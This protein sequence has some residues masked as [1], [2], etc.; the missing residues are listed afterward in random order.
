MPP[1]AEICLGALARANL[2]L[3]LSIGGAF[4]L[5]HYLPYRPT[6]DVDAW[7]NEEAGAAGRHDVV[8]CLQKALAPCGEVRVRC[9]GDVSSVE[10]SQ[11]ARTVFSFQIAQRTARLLP[12]HPSPFAGLQVDSLD[13]LVA[14]KMVALVERGAPRDF[15][16]IHAVCTHG[17][18][19]AEQCW[20][21]WHQRQ[22]LADANADRGRATLA[23]RSHLE[24]IV[25]ARP[26][27][28]IADAQARTRAQEVRTWIVGVLLDAL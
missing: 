23:V 17:L 27:A 8:Q 24:R 4:G 5:A 10:L 18:L 19:T 1:F 22:E 20:A 16:D 2:G 3:Y 11:Q 6:Y 7:W 25:L 9:W 26:L 12:S 14:A 21:L 13:D 28:S 15:V